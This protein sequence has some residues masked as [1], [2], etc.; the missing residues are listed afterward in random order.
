[1]DELRRLTSTIPLVFTQVGDPIDS[2]L[3]TNLAQPGGNITGFSAFEPDMGGK[4]LGVLKE[5][6]PT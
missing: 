1:V 5:A 6:A 4:W 3:V 2:G